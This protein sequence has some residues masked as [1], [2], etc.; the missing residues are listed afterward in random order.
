MAVFRGS[1]QFAVLEVV[2]TTLTD[3]I[4]G[5][6]CLGKIPRELMVLFICLAAFVCGL[7]LVTKVLSLLSP[8]SNREPIKGSVGRR[9]CTLHEAQMSA[10]QLIRFVSATVSFLRVAH[11]T[12]GN[13]GVSPSHRRR[14]RKL[15]GSAFGAAQLPK[16]RNST[17]TQ[18]R[19][20]I[21]SSGALPP[22]NPNA[23]NFT[24]G[25]SYDSGQNLAILGPAPSQMQRFWGRPPPPNS[26][27][28]PPLPT[29]SLTLI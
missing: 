3:S 7:P 23:K 21:L 11:E 14:T 4:G 20:T 16:H 19:R 25:D 22:P 5:R 28:S 18:W 12:L 13:P 10:E 6:G 24:R 1:F 15:P 17:N 29:P 27:A 9:H 8:E 26:E 2:F